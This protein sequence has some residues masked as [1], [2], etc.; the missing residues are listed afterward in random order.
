MYHTYYQHKGFIRNR[1]RIAE[2]ERERGTNTAKT[3]HYLPRKLCSSA[4]K[5]MLF[6]QSIFLPRVSFSNI[7]RWPLNKAPKPKH[8]GKLSHTKVISLTGL[9]HSGCFKK[10]E[11]EPE[12]HECLSLNIGLVEDVKPNVKAKVKSRSWR[13]Q[14]G[15][16]AGDEQ[17]FKW[18]SLKSSKNTEATGLLGFNCTQDWRW[19]C[20]ILCVCQSF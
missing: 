8:S 5:G 20:L 6:W 11:E 16:R 18:V 1:G 10:K 7:M 4:P 14:M 9:N 12:T 17:Y 2:N 19:F 15:N 13:E 3:M